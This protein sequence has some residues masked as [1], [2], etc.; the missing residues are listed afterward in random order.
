MNCKIF[1]FVLVCG[2]GYLISVFDSLLSF[3]KTIVLHDN[4]ECKRIN[5]ETGTED[6]AVFGDFLIGATTDPNPVFFLHLS[7]SKTLPGYLISLNTKSKEVSRI[8]T[9]DFPSKFQMNPH[10]IYLFQQKTLYVLSHSYSKGGEMIFLFD[11]ELSNGKVG[12]TYRGLIK[13]SDEHGIYN[14]IAIVDPEH[15]YISQWLPFPN[16][17][18]GRDTSLFPSLYQTITLGF[19]ESNG[20]KFCKVHGESV[21]CEYKVR[22]HMMNG[23][24][25]HGNQLF[26]ADSVMRT[27][28]VHEIQENFDLKKIAEVKVEVVAD[29][30]HYHEGAI[31][32]AGVGRSF[33]F[34]LMEESIKHGGAK[35]LAPGGVSKVS[36]VDGKWTAEELIMQ[37]LINAPTSS[38]IAGDEI[39]ISSAFDN[40]IVYCPRNKWNS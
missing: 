14:T 24:A 39:F 2:L 3:S 36:I 18:E 4:S 26:V 40:A 1:C 27:V 22:G 6:L 31:Y 8:P 17:V 21:S 15:F 34:M 37:D 38:A 13:I 35:H 33:D 20:V 5:L 23:L 16:S 12:A 25:L 7:A 30:L 29:N 19:T 28:S 10:G 9:K 32:A 11:L